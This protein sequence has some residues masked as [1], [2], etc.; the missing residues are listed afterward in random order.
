MYSYPYDWYYYRHIMYPTYYTTYGYDPLGECYTEYYYYE[1]QYYCYVGP[2]GASGGYY[3]IDLPPEN[4]VGVDPAYYY[5]YGPT[6]YYEDP[7]F[8]SRNVSYPDLYTPYDYDPYGVCG[9]YYYLYGDY[10]YCF[11]G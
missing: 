10:Y 6:Y 4:L 5:Y 11:A 7:W 3:L 2:D 8:Y 9:T 1:N